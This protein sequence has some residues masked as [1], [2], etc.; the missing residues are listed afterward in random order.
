MMEVGR[1]SAQYRVQKVSLFSFRSRILLRQKCCERKSALSL[2]LRFVCFGLGPQNQSAVSILRDFLFV[3][4]NE[5]N[6]N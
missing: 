6:A 4:P 1:A 2:I 5:S 3:C